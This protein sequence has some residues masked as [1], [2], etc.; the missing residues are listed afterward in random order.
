M[1]GIEKPGEKKFSDFR[2]TFSSFGRIKN[3]IQQECRQKILVF[4]E[5]FSLVS[6]TKA[7]KS[8]IKNKLFYFG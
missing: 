5:Y 4:I 1:I 7:R 3:I 8:V 2:E 6:A